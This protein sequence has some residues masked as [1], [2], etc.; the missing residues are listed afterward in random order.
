MTVGPPPFDWF[1]AVQKG[2]A[3]AAVLLLGAVGWMDR[4][5]RRL[6]REIAARDLKLEALSERFI[7]LMTKIEMALFGGRQRGF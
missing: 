1:D 5:R 3:V 2:G 7:V 4:E 6:L